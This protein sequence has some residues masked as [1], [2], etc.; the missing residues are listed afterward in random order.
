MNQATQASHAT[1]VSVEAPGLA[2]AS[3]LQRSRLS[4]LAMLTKPRLSALV[5]LTALMG[6]FFGAREHIDPVLLLDSVLGIALVAAGASAL[7]QF[8]ERDSDKL[9]RRTQDRPLP[10]GRMSPG[11]VLYFGVC[12]SMLGMS[13][14]LV[15]VNAE[16][17]LWSAITLGL[18]VFVYTPLKRRTT[19]NTLVGAVPGAIPPLIGYAAARGELAPQAWALFAILF[20]WQLPHFLAIAW[21]HRDDYRRAG[22]MMLPQVDAEGA[23]TGR[24]IVVH[25]LTLI[26]VTLAPFVLHMS[27]PVYALGAVVMGLAFLVFGIKFALRRTDAAAR[28]LFVASVI[29]LPLLL[30]L[31]MVDGQ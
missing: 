6:F 7:N 22:L 17:A 12:A 26:P 16:A 24:Q 18:Y 8:L 2:A 19:L 13:Y 1:Q 29:Y 28:R 21:M 11:A 3:K 31:M 27:G 9:M 5:L 25:S 14:L 30:A 10:A 4:D 20:L 15:R 23:S